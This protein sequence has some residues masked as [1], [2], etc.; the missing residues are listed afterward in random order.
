MSVTH[1]DLLEPIGDLVPELFPGKDSAAIN[2]LLDAFIADGVARTPT[3]LS[4]G[5]QDL[6]VTA[7]SYGRAYRNVLS[8]MS[9]TPASFSLT[10]EGSQTVLG[11]Q[12]RT[13]KDLAKRWE[14]EF[15]TIIGDAPTPDETPT[16]SA[17]NSYVW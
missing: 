11:E 13:F 8:R 5:S 15:D 12:I 1:D 4:S 9:R 17:K 7:W 3:T 16:A 2:A 10:N 6:A 14:S